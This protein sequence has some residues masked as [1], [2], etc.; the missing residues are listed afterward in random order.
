MGLALIMTIPLLRYL[1]LTTKSAG[2]R[3]LLVG[4]MLLCAVAA[5]GS[6]S[7]GALLGLAAMGSFLWLKSRNKMF[8]ALLGAMA[9]GI[10]LLVMPQQWYDRMATIQTYDQDQS[11]IG[12]INAWHMAY[13]MAKDRPLGGGFHSFQYLTFAMYAPDPD[14]VHDSHSIYFEVL[15]EHG[16]GGL[17][18]FLLLGLM[19]W[20]TASWIIDRARRDREKRW[21]ADLAQMVQVSLVGYAIAGAFLGLAYFDFYYTLVA[22][23]VLTKTVVLAQD[24][25]RSTEI[26]ETP[27]GQR[28]GHRVAAPGIG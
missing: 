21:A 24:A 17:A 8:T 23:I 7:R 18:L 1:Q 6:Q 5:V 27:K 13:N 16:F 19:T 20:R 2:V 3:A 14:N 22:I 25:Q 4:S 12:R 9:I 15:G 10:V 26:A 28:I 11:A